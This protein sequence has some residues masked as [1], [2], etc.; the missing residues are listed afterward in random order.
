MYC[1]ILDIASQR[2]D[3]LQTEYECQKNNFLES[4]DKEELDITDGQ[5]RAEFKLKLIT[6][7]QERDFQN[8]K[9]EKE[10]QRATEKNDARL[11]VS[12][13]VVN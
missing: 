4:W 9:K 6:Y 13:I 5:D 11:E 7:V 12:R 2:L 1:D 3:K 8:F 10:I